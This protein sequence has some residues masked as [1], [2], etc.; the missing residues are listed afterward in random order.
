MRELSNTACFDSFCPLYLIAV[1]RWMYS[2]TSKETSSDILTS[3]RQT[4]FCFKNNFLASLFALYDESEIIF[5]C[6]A[7]RYNTRI[8]DKY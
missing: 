4:I 7:L 3:F 1:R 6:C 2:G 8:Y 5:P